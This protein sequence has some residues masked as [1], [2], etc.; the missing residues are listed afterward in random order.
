MTTQIVA[1]TD[2]YIH[3]KL[4]YKNVRIPIDLPALSELFAGRKSPSILGGNIAKKETDRFSYW[5]AEPKEV[6]EFH[7]GQKDPFGKLQKALAK[8]KLV[9]DF[10]VDSRLRGNDKNEEILRYAQ[11]DKYINDLPK[12]IFRGGW[13]GYFSY[14]LGRYIEPTA[15]GGQEVVV[16]D[17]KMP[18]IR[19]SFYDR[20]IAY[21]HIAK[22]FWL[23]ALEMSDDTERWEEKLAGLEEFLVESKEI[24]VPQPVSV[25]IDNIDFSQIR[26]NIDKNYYLAAVKKIKKH[27]YDGDVYQINFSQRFECDYRANPIDLFHWQNRYNPSGYAAYVDGGRFNIVSAS[28][29]MFIT[30]RDRIIKTKP[31]KGTRPHLNETEHPQAKQINAKNFNELLLSEKE[32]AELNMIIDLERNDVAKICEPGTRKIIQPRT[33]ETYPT[34][35]HAVATVSGQIREDI[36]FCDV[37]KAMFPGGSITGAPKIRAME[38]INQTEP[39][40]RGVYTGSIGFIGIDG[41]VCLNIAIR[42]V[43]ITG[44]KAF[45]QTGGGIVADSDPQAEWQETLTKARA[46]VAG[47]RV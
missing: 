32:Q 43:I 3:C 4:H 45:A 7:A 17:L 26:S 8:Y 31:I 42:T 41:S 44:Q 22:T 35:F 39:T 20:L 38:I 5:A 19:L 36:T 16:D 46:L 33:I 37:L 30:I 10:E 34:V 13:V 2:K 11:N 40:A 15:F 27:I 14:D 25:D 6:F 1:K 9:E 18:L 28:P 23:I 12:E 29:E 47:I 24:H 21:D